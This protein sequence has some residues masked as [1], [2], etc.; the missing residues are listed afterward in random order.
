MLSV[1][2]EA[3]EAPAE[4]IAIAW[5]AVL[6]ALALTVLLLL[7]ILWLR[8]RAAARLLQDAPPVPPPAPPSEAPRPAPGET[9]P[10]PP[11]PR[12]LVDPRDLAPHLGKR[13]VLL[14][15][16]TEVV[17]RVSI[18][19]AQGGAALVPHADVPPGATP[20]TPPSTP[21]EHMR[22]AWIGLNRVYGGPTFR[23][24]GWVLV[25]IQAAAPAHV[26]AALAAIRAQQPKA[27]AVHYFGHGDSDQ[28]GARPFLTFTGTKEVGVTRPGGQKVVALQPNDGVR[29]A[30]YLTSDLAARI[31][32]DFSRAALGGETEIPKTLVVDGCGN[33]PAVDFAN[34]GARL[35][36]AVA[37]DVKGQD[38]I[39]GKFSQ[40]WAAQVNPGCF[41][42]N[43]QALAA[44]VDAV[45]QVGIG[46]SAV[47]GHDGT[48]PQRGTSTTWRRSL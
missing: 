23:Q 37:V 40:L 34:A 29:S 3:H 22:Q 28:G 5:D 42:D 26:D 47:N 19:D 41:E 45:N 8:R 21:P 20:L 25:S 31:Q 38:T 44:A 7:L 13:F 11:A 32:A 36:V 2:L 39:L 10:P 27:I 6:V 16:G 30:R 18:L 12:H 43:A 14:V 46:D 33:A 4:P 24:A 9:P 15:A 48:H 35:R 1:L 17:S